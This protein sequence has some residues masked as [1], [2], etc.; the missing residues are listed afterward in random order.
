MLR[1]R[2]NNHYEVV[3]RLFSLRLTVFLFKVCSE[4]EAA[5]AVTWLNV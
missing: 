1:L 5:Q 2:S 3:P 4:E